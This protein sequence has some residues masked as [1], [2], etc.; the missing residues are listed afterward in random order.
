MTTTYLTAEGY[1]Y[2]CAEFHGPECLE[3]P[4]PVP[5]GHFLRVVSAQAAIYAGGILAAEG[6]HPDDEDVEIMMREFLPQLRMA[7]TFNR[8]IT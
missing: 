7:I 4:K 2:R 3:Q 5:L 1:C 8:R 6:Y